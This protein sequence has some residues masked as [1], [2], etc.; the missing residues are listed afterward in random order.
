M[1]QPIKKAPTA[2][3]KTAEMFSSHYYHRKEE[4]TVGKVTN[5][6]TYSWIKKCLFII[7]KTTGDTDRYLRR[8]V[9][10]EI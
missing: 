4:E 10:K 1:K 5:Y 3:K 7:A 8:N 6:F 2:L 9:P